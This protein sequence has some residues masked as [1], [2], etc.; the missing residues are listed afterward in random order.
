MAYNHGIRIEEQATSIV[1]PITGSAGLQVVI[2]TAPIN[3][4]KDPYSV[5]NVPLIAYS[6]SEA[7]SQLGYS[8]DFKKF[9]LCQSMDASFRIFNVAPII[10][11]NVLDPKKH[12][13]DNTEASVNV[14]AKQAKLEEDG[15]LLDTLVVKDGAT[16][17]AKNEDYITSFTDD[18]KVLVSLIEGSSHAGASTLTV[19]S[20]SIDPSAVKAK[21]IIGGYD[22]ATDKESGLEL[23]RQVYPRFNMTPGLLLAPGWSQIPEVGIVLGSKCSEINGVFSCECVLDLDSSSTGAKKYSAVGEWKNK[24]GYTNKHSVVLWPQVKVGKKQYAFSAIFA[25]LTAYADAS[26][27]DV[28]NLSPSNKMAKITGLVLDDGTEV[29]LDQNQANLLNSQGVI[30]AINVNGWRT[31]GNNTAAYPGVTDPK[32]RWFCCRRFFS[33]WGNSFIMTYFQKVDDPANYRLI[34]S[35][36][37][38]ENIRGNSYTSQ[39][40]CAGAK[41]VFEEKDN[42][43]TDIL[44]GKIKFRQYLAPY[45]PAEDILNVLEFDPSMLAAAISGGGN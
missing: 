29:T 32:D 35:I 41:I 34:E 3:L 28:P 7:A 8:D 24:N 23:I 27:D 5:T 12:K 17:L 42:Q 13:K 22:A 20:T 10:F 21:D 11:I 18:G 14:V 6:F 37:D 40:K 43:I 15:I 16:T 39:G 9:T 25:A 45:T 30:T 26:N 44:N 36:V 38:S 31:W 1:A 19:K 4:A 33:W 2:G